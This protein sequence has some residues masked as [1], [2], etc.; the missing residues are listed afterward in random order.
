MN[1]FKEI[2][3]YFELEL[4]A[5]Q[6][7]YPQAYPVN[8]GRAG[9]K[10]IVRQRAYKRV[11]VPAYICSV[12][13][14]TL[15]KLDVETVSYALTPNLEPAHVPKLSDEDGFLYVNYFGI[16]DKFCDELTGRV[17]NL[18]LDLTQAFFYEPPPNVDAFNS[19]RKFVGVPDGG[20]V[21]GNFVPD[22]DLPRATSWQQC[23]HLLRRLDGDVSG[24][25]EAFKANDAAMRD[26]SPMRMSK[27]TE[28]MLQAIDFEHLKKKRITNFTFL[29]KML[30]T[31]NELS[32]EESDTSVPFCYPY[33]VRNGFE[34]KKRLI[35]NKIFIPTYWA[36][37]EDENM[38]YR[39]ECVL[40]K[41][42]VCLPVDQ[43]YSAKDMVH[44]VDTLS[45]LIAQL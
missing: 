37:F 44:V 2:G 16:K 9:L 19:A 1:C 8:F 18:I 26:W 5:G 13:Y 20:F 31:S 35:N 22:L 4:R 39:V 29:H 12:V 23:E 41:N 6:T 27:V 3:G 7:P 32:I 28:R 36:D 40:K 21:F 17:K 10:L 34:L 15:E 43:R 33:L 24:G 11:W 30:H 45:R 38:K 42:L 14:D 25:Y